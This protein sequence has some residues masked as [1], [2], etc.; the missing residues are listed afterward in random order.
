MI[1]TDFG[2]VRSFPGG[3][4][5]HV[6]ELEAA[7]SVQAASDQ[8]LQP[9]CVASR[10]QVRRSQARTRRVGVRRHR[11]GGSGRQNRGASAMPHILKRNPQIPSVSTCCNQSTKTNPINRTPCNK[12]LTE[13]FDSLE[14]L[15]N[16]NQS[17]PTRSRRFGPIDVADLRLVRSIYV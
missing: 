2:T 12:C 9:S 4:R 7:A 5:P 14:S 15:P 16:F 11:G 13:F 10:P 8:P 17:K 3:F 1:V 6:A